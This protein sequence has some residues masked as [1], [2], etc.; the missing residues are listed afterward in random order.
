MYVETASTVEGNTV[1]K[2]EKYGDNRCP[3]GGMLVVTQEVYTTR[4]KNLKRGRFWNGEHYSVTELKCLRCKCTFL[5]YSD[6]GAFPTRQD[7]KN[8]I[9]SVANP[10]LRELLIGTL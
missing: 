8:A 2:S 1:L 3:C 7:V 6:V 5:T 4:G 10:I 9:N